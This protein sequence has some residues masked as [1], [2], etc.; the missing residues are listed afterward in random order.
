[1]NRLSL[2]P[3]AL[4]VALIAAACGGDGVDTPSSK[5][6]E[7]PAWDGEELFTYTLTQNDRVYGKC[8]A[9]TEPDGDT[10][11][12]RLHCFN[13]TGDRDDR[14]VIVESDT[15]TPLRSERTV[16]SI[17]TVTTVE[18]HPPTATFTTAEEGKD[19]RTRDRDLPT[20]D[21]EDDPEPGYYD[22]NSLFWLLRGLPLEEDW[23][24]GFHDINPGALVQIV[25]AEFE[26]RERVEIDVPAGTFDTWRVLLRTPSVGQYLWVE[27]EAPHRV[28]RADLD[29]VRYELSED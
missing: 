10:T 3:L 23:T 13:D 18:Y 22:D 12:L 29:G 5:I 28:I 17:N 19:P 6:F 20:K 4:G 2:A 26:V 24:G 11:T 7:S 8:E 1:M 16:T 27:V 15:L 14:T 21:S 25:E 9:T